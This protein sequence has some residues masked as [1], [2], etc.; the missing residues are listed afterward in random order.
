MG[1]P[2]NGPE[3]TFSQVPSGIPACSRDKDGEVSK[4]YGNMRMAALR[5]QFGQG[6][7]PGHRGHTKLKEI[8]HL[9]DE[10]SLGKLLDDQSRMIGPALKMATKEELRP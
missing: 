4:K 1:M 6:F 10:H 3:A 5:E 8:L 9:L 7:A 2:A